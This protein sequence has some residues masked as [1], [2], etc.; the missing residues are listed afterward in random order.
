MCKKYL[1]TLLLA[2]VVSPAMA[3]DTGTVTFNGKI[4][5]DS[6]AVD[7]NGSTTNGVVTF[8]NLSTTSFGAD[9]TVGDSQPLVITVT[10]CDSAIKNLN[11]VF[12]GTR[13]S[14]YDDEVLKATGT[15][16][17]LGVR[18]LPEGSSSYIKFDGSEPDVALRKANA[19]SVVFNYTAEVIQVGSA[20]PTVGDYAAQTTYT[21]IYR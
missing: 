6:C 5:A 12:D 16:S 19:A 10:K 15:A 17:N 21:L 9:K 14:G 7:V 4:V 18:L 13:I 20:V 2:A 8:N 3:V 1:A 11:V